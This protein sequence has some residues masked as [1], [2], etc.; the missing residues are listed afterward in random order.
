MPHPLDAPSQ[1]PTRVH[2]CVPGCFSHFDS[3]RVHCPHRLHSFL[4]SRPGVPFR[5]WRARDLTICFMPLYSSREDICRMLYRLRSALPCSHG[6]ATS[7][8]AVQADTSANTCP[9]G[10]A[11]SVLLSD[12][13]DAAADI[14]SLFSGTDTHLER[15][16]YTAGWSSMSHSSSDAQLLSLLHSLSTTPWWNP[17]LLLSCLSCN[18]PRDG[19]LI[20]DRKHTQ[21]QTHNHIVSVAGPG[22]KPGRDGPLRSS[23]HPPSRNLLTLLLVSSVR[24]APISEPRVDASAARHA[25][26]ILP[27]CPFI[28]S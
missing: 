22:P 21:P 28:C 5:P 14:T 9:D 25:S 20:S 27:S 26:R 12:R 23:P 6:P 7:F 17:D 15:C 10:E 4:S 19:Q 16:A 18:A 3:S 24:S 13:A 11:D 2:L 1:I 8:Y